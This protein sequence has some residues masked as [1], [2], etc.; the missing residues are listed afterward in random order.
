MVGPAGAL[1]PQPSRRLGAERRAPTTAEGALARHERSAATL[2]G[3]EVCGA[4]AAA[5]DAT[6]EAA[7]EAVCGVVWRTRRRMRLFALLLLLALPPC[8]EAEKA[9]CGGCGRTWL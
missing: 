4:P 8:D 3:E 6:H 7:Y 2:C 1:Q 5:Y 9:E